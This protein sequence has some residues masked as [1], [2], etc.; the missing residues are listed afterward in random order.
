MIHEPGTPV[1]RYLGT[2]AATQ[3]PGGTHLVLEAI[4][5]HRCAPLEVTGD[6]A[7]LEPVPNPGASDVAR[8]GRPVPGGQGLLQPGLQ[9]LLQLGATRGAGQCYQGA[10]GLPAPP[11]MT[12]TLGRSRKRCWVVFTTGTPPQ[13]L[14]CGFCKE[15]KRGSEGARDAAASPEHSGTGGPKE[16]PSHLQLHSIY[17]FATLITLVPP[18]FL[19]IAEGTGALYEAVG[20]EPLASFASQ[21]LHCVLQ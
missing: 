20:Q 7:R 21:L 17:E 16:I 19:V 9:A 14:H 6:A 10:N 2:G 1:S 8:V 3:G 12:L 15:E 18:G 11:G 13:S 5:R 4:E